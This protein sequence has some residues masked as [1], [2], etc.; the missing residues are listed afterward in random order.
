MNFLSD[1]TGGVHPRIMAALTAANQGHVPSYGEDAITAAARDRLRELFEAPAAAVHFLPTG[2]AA[3]ALS[4]ALLTP[5]WGKVFCHADAHVLTSECGAPEFF[6]AGAR[7]VPVAGAAGRVSAGALREA[8]AAHGGG[9]VHGGS[10]AA[11]S[12]SNATEWG[13]VYGPEEV[14]ALAAVARE[15]GLG[16]HM[17]GARLSNALA[18]SDARPADLTWRAGVDVLSLGGTKNGC[19]G[20]EAVLVFDPA[21]SDEL[22]FRR[23]RAGA[24]LSKHRYLSAQM[25]AWLDGGLWLQLARHANAMARE[26]GLGLSRLP[27]VRL[28][29]RVETNAVF[30]TLPRALHRRACAAGICYHLWPHAQQDGGNG[31][32]SVRMVCGWDTRLEDVTAV[33]AALS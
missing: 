5:A 24:L 14:A 2:T 1:N 18:A 19:M 13:T 11:L 27:G 7:L 12:L 10:N 8:L 20:V 22:E 16:L 32:V 25:L 21:K 3:N 28:D 31:P 26:L 29:Q 9:G 23:K 30:A 4:L 15:H 6:A 17:D 33:L